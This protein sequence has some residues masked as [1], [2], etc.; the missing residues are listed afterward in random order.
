[1]AFRSIPP[2]WAGIR[3]CLKRIS[4]FIEADPDGETIRLYYPRAIAAGASYQLDH[5]LIE[6]GGRNVTDP[7]EEAVIKPD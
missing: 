2:S 1:M 3:P 6:F 5:I 4:H 7:G